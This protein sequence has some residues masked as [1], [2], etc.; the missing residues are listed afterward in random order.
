MVTEER[1]KT[2]AEL[3]EHD[4]AIQFLLDEVSDLRRD[5]REL[6][7]H[8]GLNRNEMRQTRESFA[9]QWAEITEGKHLLGDAEFEQQMVGLL[10][11]YSGYSADWFKG[12]KVLDAGCG[13]GRWSYVMAKL[14]AK[15]TAIDQSASGV[16]AVSR[17]FENFPDVAVQQADILEPIPFKPEFDLVWS[18]GVT[19]HTGFTRLA[20]RHVAEMVKPGGRLFLMIYGEPVNKAEFDEINNYVDL[21]RK[22]QFMSFDE[23]EK[24]LG[25]IY[26]PEFVH[27]YFD[28]VSPIVNDLHR[29]EEIENWLRQLN[30]VD[31]RSTFASRNHHLVAD[32]PV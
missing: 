17:H 5:S 16:A 2:L 1:A 6:L 28:A 20:V 23:K 22:T 8:A 15:V 26:P 32:R 25:S 18:Y 11:T 21:R 14:G 19:H 29:F 9:Y 3:S 30:F 31:V 24:F 27:G 12:K 4:S 7:G 10:E 13:N